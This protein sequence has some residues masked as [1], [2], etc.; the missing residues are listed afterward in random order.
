MDGDVR[1]S[2]RWV[3]LADGAIALRLRS[4]RGDRVI[5]RL[6][7]DRALWQRVAAEGPWR[8]RPQDRLVVNRRNLPLRRLV[9]AFARP[10]PPHAVVRQAD[11]LDCRRASLAIV[12]R[13]ALALDA[14][15]RR[16]WGTAAGRPLRP[17]ARAATVVADGGDPV[18]VA[19]EPLCGGEVG[20]G[21]EQM[22]DIGLPEVAQGE[23]VDAHPGRARQRVVDRLGRQPSSSGASAVPSSRWLPVARPLI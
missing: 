8:W 18:G 16:A 4:L 2:S 21:I 7:Q 10:L 1:A 17:C 22:A 5:V 23:V 3:R 15:R 6:D 19:R 14:Y 12:S 20:P 9:A 11:P 13:S